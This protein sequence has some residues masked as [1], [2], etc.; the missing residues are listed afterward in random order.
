MDDTKERVWTR[1]PQRLLVA[2]GGDSKQQLWTDLPKT[3]LTTGGPFTQAMEKWDESQAAT[4]ERLIEIALKDYGIK[5][6]AALQRAAETH[7]RSRVSEMAHLIGHALR[8][9]GFIDDG[10]APRPVRAGASKR[11][12]SSPLRRAS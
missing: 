1:L 11:K 4:V 8:L 5:G 10:V 6:E 3:W 9:K 12:P 7:D 2:G